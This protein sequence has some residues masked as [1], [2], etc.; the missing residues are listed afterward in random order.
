VAETPTS[1][2]KPGWREALG[3]IADL[4]VEEDVLLAPMTTFRIG[5]PAEVLVQPQTAIAAADLWR[6]ADA[7]GVPVTILGGGTNVLISDHGLPGIVVDLSGGFSYLHEHPRTD[8]TSI[9]EVGAGCGTSKVVRRALVRGLRGPEVLAGVPGSIGGALIMN[10]GGHEGE[11]KSIV[12]R[13]LI[14]DQGELRWLSR[15]EVGFTYRA[16]KF[17]PRSVVLGAELELTP[18]DAAALKSFVKT[19]QVRRKSTQ[20][21]DLPNAGSIFKNPEGQFAGK[22][23]Q[24]AGCKGWKEG[25]AEVSKK[26]ANFIVNRGGAT[27][28]EVALLAKRVRARVLEH[29]GVTLQ[30]E[31]RFLGQFA[32]EV[33]G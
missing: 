23:I 31:V 3:D 16:S 18:G 11:I 19:S 7:H 20:P 32:P 1:E 27:A 4:I 25:G 12:R 15:D 9:W 8:G 5:G 13:V 14:V 24:E 10:A 26:H 30:L 21:L 2:R 22:L 6:L 29:A 28:H 17:P 33:L